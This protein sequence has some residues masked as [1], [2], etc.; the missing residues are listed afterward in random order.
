[1][2]SPRGLDFSDTVLY[3]ADPP[4]FYMFNISQPEAPVFIEQ[5]GM[6]NYYD[7]ITYGN[8]LF[9]ISDS[10]TDIFSI[11]NPTKPELLATIQ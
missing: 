11:V 6:K 5:F 9:A 1:M 10:A 8:E 2:T 7:V 4:G 3:V